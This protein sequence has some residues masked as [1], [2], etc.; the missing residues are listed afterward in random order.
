MN[1]AIGFGAS[2]LA[3]TFTKVTVQG[4]L[5]ATLGLILLTGAGAVSAQTTVVDVGD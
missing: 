4:L 1:I 2:I 3:S 5:R